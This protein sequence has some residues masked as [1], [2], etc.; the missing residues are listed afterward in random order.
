[1][2]QTLHEFKARQDKNKQILNSLLNFVKEG[3]NLGIEIENVYIEKIEKAMNDIGNQKL[4]IA[5]VGGFSEG[6]TSIAAAWLERL[7]KTSMNINHQESSDAVVV[8]DIDNDLELIDTPGLFGFKEKYNDLS[9]IQKYKDITKQYVSQAHII[10]YVLNPFNPI[11]E[12]HKEDLEWLFRTLNLLDRT[13]FVLSRFD[14]VADIEDEQDYQRQFSIKRDNVIERLETLIGLKPNEKSELSVVAVSANPFDEGI[15]YWLTHKEEFIKLSHIRILQDAT[16]QKISSNGGKDNIVEE[17]KRSIIQDI[18]NKQMPIVEEQYRQIND[19]IIGFSKLQQKLEKDL[20]SVQ[21]NITKAQINLSE[22]VED[23]FSDIILQIKDASLENFDSV[24]E[25]TIGNEG[26]K[27]DTAIKNAFREHT[28][29]VNIQIIEIATNYKTDMNIFQGKI[30]EITNKYK[31][32]GQQVIT[33]E[34]L[35]IAKD[36]VVTSIKI[37]I[38]KLPSAIA[39]IANKAATILQGLNVAKFAGAASVGV[40]LIGPITEVCETAQHYKKQ[41][42]FKDA[43]NKLISELNQPR[44]ELLEIINA[45]NFKENYFRKAIELEEDL[46]RARQQE[47]QGKQRQIAFKQW[48]ENGNAI[49]TRMI[50]HK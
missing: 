24:V 50:E 43:Q 32:I 35:N 45:E 6:K 1:M 19:E 44:K 29:R 20:S 42:E 48:L 18:L 31:G 2:N 26:S 15:E 36:A 23:F 9:Q 39:T 46:E 28:E 21:Q 34:N 33:L 11:K 49:K 38:P 7:D 16:K 10:L 37:I 41:Q 12:S 25:K 40:A 22:F 27:I 3:Q 47:E 30:G 5:L 13:I 14:E 17:A 8:Y 4:K